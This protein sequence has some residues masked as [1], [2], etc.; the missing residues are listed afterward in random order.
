MSDHAHDAPAEE[1]HHP[2][3]VKVWAILTALLVVSVTGPMLG[4]RTVTLI[5]AF[6]I[7]LVRPIWSSRT[8]CISRSRNRPYTGCWGSRS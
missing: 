2:N 5:A 3:Y 8:S 6:G 7:A 4:I 1:H